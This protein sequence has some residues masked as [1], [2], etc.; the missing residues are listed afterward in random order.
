MPSSAAIDPRSRIGHVHPGAADPDRAPGLHCGATGQGLSGAPD[1]PEPDGN[2]V[3]PHRDGEAAE[4][5]RAQG[6]RLPMVARRLGL[7]ALPGRGARPARSGHAARLASLRR[8]PAAFLFAALP[9]A[10][11]PAA[12]NPAPVPGVA[13]AAVAQVAADPAAVAP[14][15]VAPVAVAY[16]AYAAALPVLRLHASYAI[17]QAAYEVKLTF[18]TA[19]VF[20]IVLHA[21]VDSTATGLLADGRARPSRYYAVGDMRGRPHVTQID[22][23]A[24]VPRVVQLAPPLKD[25]NEPVPEALQLGTIDSLSAM[26]ELVDSVARTGRC[27]GT[28]RTFD[29]RRLSELSARTVGEET[30][31]PTG[32]STFSGRAL[33]CDLEGRQVAGFAKDADRDSAARPLHGSA[34]FASLAPGT[35]AVPVRISFETRFFGAATAYLV[36]K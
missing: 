18:D 25:D 31:A 12:A 36:A 1:L 28:Q 33:R 20:G 35:P 2:G 6:G 8:A 14:A 29:G 9:L 34:W 22:Y 32:R 24:G 5:P 11:G 30:L 17:G 15:A 10:S 3:G 26:A 13:S 4:G 16:V 23:A 21:H 27:D 19:G 7:D